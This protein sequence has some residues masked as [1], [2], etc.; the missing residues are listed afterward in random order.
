MSEFLIIFFSIS[1]IAFTLW[2]S[3]RKTKKEKQYEEYLEESLE[4]EH[5]YDPET[6]AKITLEQAESGHWINHD[7]EFKPIDLRGLEKFQ[8]KEEKDSLKALNYLIT[9]YF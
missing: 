9:A 2:I 6:G 8:T 5:L 7:N 3:M 1:I 4:D